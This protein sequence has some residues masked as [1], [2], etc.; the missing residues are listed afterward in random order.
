MMKS[1]KLLIVF[2]C[3]QLRMISLHNKETVCAVMGKKLWHRDQENP[4]QSQ[5][6]ACQK[7][8]SISTEH[9]NN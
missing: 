9:I 5:T 3:P 4:V 7:G 1:T 8:S 6:C 2:L